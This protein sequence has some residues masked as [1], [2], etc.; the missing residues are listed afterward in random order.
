[1]PDENGLIAAH[2]RTIRD[3][4]DTFR[5]LASGPWAPFKAASLGADV[6][7]STENIVIL[8]VAGPTSVQVI[9]RLLGRSIRE[10]GQPAVEAEAASP[11]RKT[12]ILRWNHEDILDVFASQF[13]QGEEYKHIEF[14]T[15]RSRSRADTPTS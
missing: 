5:Q 7:I 13:E 11:R 10:L 3:S 1:M 8:Q 4:D 6:Q 9:E 15:P 2:G 14:P 12:V